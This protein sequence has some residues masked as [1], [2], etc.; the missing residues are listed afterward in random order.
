MP[1]LK[2]FDLRSYQKDIKEEFFIKFIIKIFSIDLNDIKLILTNNHFLLD[3]L[4]Y[5]QFEEYSINE[6]KKMF[7]NININKYNTLSIAKNTILIRKF[8]N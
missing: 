4:R 6:I 8:F 2:Y 7:P 5:E 3:K 1:N